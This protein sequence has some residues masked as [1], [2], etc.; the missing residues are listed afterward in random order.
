MVNQ[1]PFNSNDQLCDSLV[2]SRQVVNGQ[3]ERQRT[4]T[5]KPVNKEVSKQYLPGE[6]RLQLHDR[7]IGEALKSELLTEDLDKLSP[8][9]WLVAKQDSAHISSLTDQVVRGRKIIVTEKPGLHLVWHYDRIFVKPI[10]KYLLSHA[11]WEFYLISDA[12]PIELAS[13]NRLFRAASGF[14]RS[15]NHLI[16]HRSDFALAMKDDHRLLPKNTKYGKFINFIK[17]F[18]AIE[19]S[20]VS[21]RYRFGELRLSRL[22]FWSKVFLFR[23]TYEK[24]EKQYGAYFNRFFAPILFLFGVFSVLLSAMQVILAVQTLV[25]TGES[26][27]TFV[28]V[29]QRFSVFTIVFVAVVILFLLFLLVIMSSREVIFALRD[30]YRRSRSRV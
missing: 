1:V 4:P 3:V 10:P 25:E 22:N 19:D 18:E 17:S 16:R 12:S 21:P 7:T 5:E 26:W 27:V 13:R 23:F 8:N 14:L 24:A 11:F 29:S 15:Y 28:S 6:P 20:A 30:L 2:V 9:L